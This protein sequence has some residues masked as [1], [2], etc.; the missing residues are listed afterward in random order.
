MSK[1]KKDV[2]ELF[3]HLQSIQINRNASGVIVGQSNKGKALNASE[4]LY[5]LADRLNDGAS[6]LREYDSILS[7]PASSKR[8]VEEVRRNLKRSILPLIEVA[9][10]SAHKSAII[11]APIPGSKYAHVRMERKRAKEM[12]EQFNDKKRPALHLI[13]DHISKQNLPM[14]TSTRN[15]R[16]TKRKKLPTV[17]THLPI[18]NNG[19]QYS[20]TKCLEVIVGTPLNFSVKGKMNAK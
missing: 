6:E 5:T 16:R 14:Q 12:L 17:N 1:P 9:S 4:K 10:L 18:P 8:A 7:D 20:K 15:T 3:H 2:M 13:N 19:K 11:L